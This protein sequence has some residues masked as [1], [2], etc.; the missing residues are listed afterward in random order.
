MNYS[1]VALP[2]NTKIKVLDLGVQHCYAG[3]ECTLFRWQKYLTS[4]PPAISTAY[5]GFLLCL[6][7][8]TDP[9][10][11]FAAAYSLP[12]IDFFWLSLISCRFF[13]ILYLFCAHFLLPDRRGL[14]PAVRLD[15]WTMV[16]DCDEL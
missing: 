4:M 8:V 13:L 15:L 1:A 7:L 5:C 3:V 14:A 16:I 2:P 12:C 11:L 6:F 9:C 10:C